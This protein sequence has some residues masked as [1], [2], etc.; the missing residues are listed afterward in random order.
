MLDTFRR[1]KESGLIKGRIEFCEKPERI[2]GILS[3]LLFSSLSG[4]T[5]TTYGPVVELGPSLAL[6]RML[7]TV[8][9]S[10]T[11]TAGPGNKEIP[12]ATLFG[13]GKTTL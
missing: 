5:L 8:I 1:S 4:T 6:V 13:L 7:F 12:S 2:S 10:E 9:V 3:P 11:S